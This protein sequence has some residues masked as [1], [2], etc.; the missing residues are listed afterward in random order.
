MPSGWVYPED[1]T[2]RVTSAQG[3]HYYNERIGA[4]DKEVWEWGSAVAEGGVRWSFTT[5][6]FVISSKLCGAGPILSLGVFGPRRSGCRHRPGT[7][8]GPVMQRSLSAMGSG[9]TGVWD[10]VGRS[11]ALAPTRDRRVE[12]VA[13]GLRVAS[14]RSPSRSRLSCVPRRRPAQ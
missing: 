10:P 14:D 5:E 12:P 4:A 2:L 1:A 3:T 7:R 11:R 13:Y 6:S 8:D 9:S